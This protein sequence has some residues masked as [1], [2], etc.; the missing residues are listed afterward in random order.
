MQW[1]NVIKPRTTENV[2]AQI[3]LGVV[4]IIIYTV[5]TEIERRRDYARFEA[6][7]MSIRSQ[8]LS[9]QD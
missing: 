4:G 2:L 9:D 1:K 6:L 8:H 3:T 7:K 5:I